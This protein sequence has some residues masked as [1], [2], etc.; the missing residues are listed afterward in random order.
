[1]C[2]RF[3]IVR[4][5]EYLNE[6]A[7]YCLYFKE[8]LKSLVLDFRLIDAVSFVPIKRKPL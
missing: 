5:Y 7:N 8:S 1:M 6:C 2:I 3:K 4:R